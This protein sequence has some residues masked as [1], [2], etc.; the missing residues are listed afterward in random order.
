MADRAISP[1]VSFFERWNF[2]LCIKYLCTKSYNATVGDSLLAMAS[3]LTSKEVRFCFF[4]AG[5]CK[6]YTRQADF[7]LKCYGRS[8]PVSREVSLKSTTKSKL[9]RFAQDQYVLGKMMVDP[10]T[11]KHAV[12]R[13]VCLSNFITAHCPYGKQTLSTF[14][15]GAHGF[16]RGGQALRNSRKGT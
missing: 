12:V 1:T 8:Y 11:N 7:V 14:D 3:K 15:G 10:I 4:S 13:Y 16:G 9:V 6:G 2:A 5:C